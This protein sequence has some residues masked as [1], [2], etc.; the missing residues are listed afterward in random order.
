MFKAA[1]TFLTNG[2]FASAKYAEVPSNEF[3]LIGRIAFYVFW[4][5]VLILTHTVLMVLRCLR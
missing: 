4:V 1:V 3:E 5:G 2:K